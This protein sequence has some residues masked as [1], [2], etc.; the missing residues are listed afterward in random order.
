MA[1]HSTGVSLRARPIKDG[2]RSLFLDISCEGRRSRKSLNLFLLPETSAA[3]RTLNARTMRTAEKIR[4]QEE[5]RL[6]AETYGQSQP[7]AAAVPLL[8][9][10]DAVMAHRMAD[11]AHSTLLQWRM[12][13]HKL[14]G[15]P[16]ARIT[17]DRIDTKWCERFKLWLDRQPGRKG[18]IT[19]SSKR[20]YMAKLGCV[21][22]EA[23]RTGLMGHNP[24]KAVA[25]YKKRETARVFLTTEELRRLAA[26][27]FRDGGLRR[28]FLFSCLTGL[29]ASDVTALTWGQVS[30]AGGMTRL[31][32]RQKKTRGVEYLDINPQAAALMGDR[33]EAEAKVFADF[34]YNGKALGRLLEWCRDAGIDKH[35]TFHS[36]RHTFAVLMLEAGADLYTVSKLLGHREI[37]TTQVYAHVVDKTKRAAVMLPDIEG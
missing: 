37:K 33:G 16:E 13:R 24:L 28:A 4:D 32:F 26:T 29:R 7:S 20:E 34:C 14:A 18:L 30:E 3:N 15:Y 21:F 10:Y 11:A 2:T 23:V 19:S 36:G 12:I 1:K 22:N 31:T 8:E 25:M 17:V 27:P 6:I 5:E 35:V 9:M